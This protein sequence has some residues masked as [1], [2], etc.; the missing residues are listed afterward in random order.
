[1][2]QNLKFLC[3][4][5]GPEIVTIHPKKDVFASSDN[6]NCSSDSYPE[7]GFKWIE[8]NAEMS[9]QVPYFH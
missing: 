6:L 8:K 1:M 7:S 4:A 2:L 5:E 3:E 9:T